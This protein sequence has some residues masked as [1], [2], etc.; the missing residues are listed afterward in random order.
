MKKPRIT[1]L[2]VAKAADVSAATI[3]LVMNDKAHGRV[4]IETQRRVREAATELG[5]TIDRRA[6]SL[7]T[8]RSGLVGFVVPDVVNP[9]FGLVHM[10]LL[11]ELGS[12]HQ[13][14]TVATDIGEHAA[15][16]NIA[17]LMAFGVDAFVAISIDS[18]YLAPLH[19]NVPMVLVD[20]DH[21]APGAT[22]VNYE[23]E[24]GARDLASHLRQLG[25]RKMV[26]IDGLTPS[27]TFAARRIAFLDA[28]SGGRETPIVTR[29]AVDMD[30]ASSAVIAEIELWRARGATALV[31]ATDVQAYGALA[32]LRQKGI[33]VPGEISV[34]GF[35]DLPF[36]RIV[37][38]E[39]TSVHVPTEK[40]AKIAA[41]QLRAVLSGGTS[42]AA[43]LA[44]DVELRTRQSTGLAPKK[45]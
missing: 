35:D 34:A 9:F 37:T 17:Q 28:I 6:R 24:K 12:R 4:P 39:L 32:G 42:A 30:E 45:H 23:V 5:Y 41:T 7:A 40:L 43:G 3:S 18:A 33:S 31:C 14:L 11:R 44:I 19:A 38:P 36:S 29:T 10:A 26:Y 21:P 15:R 25:H 20:T 8:G 27:R 13:V 22:I 1:A 2:D 16:H